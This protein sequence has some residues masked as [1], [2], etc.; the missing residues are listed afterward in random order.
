[1]HFDNIVFNV[2]YSLADQDTLPQPLRLFE[3]KQCVVELLVLSSPDFPLDSSKHNYHA[4]LHWYGQDDIQRKLDIRKLIR[5]ELKQVIKN[6][7][8]ALFVMLLFSKIVI[9]TIIHLETFSK[10]LLC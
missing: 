7:C 10:V 6:N 8:F 2:M 3:S 1:M 9:M 4:T 5:K